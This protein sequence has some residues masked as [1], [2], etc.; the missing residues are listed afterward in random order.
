M[1]TTNNPNTVPYP[2][3]LVEAKYYYFG[4]PSRPL[5][6]ARSSTDVW[7]E[8]RG[9]EAY[10]LPRESSPIGLHPLREIW[11]AT[12]GPALVHYLDSKG[13][14]WTSLDPV[15]MGYTHESSHPVIIWIGVVAGSLSAEDGVQVAT[16]CKSILSAHD[17]NDV[18]VEIRESEVIRSAGPKMCKPTVTS[19][20][21]SEV[22]EPFST[23]LGLPICAEATPSIEGTGGFF[24]SDPRNP[25]KIYLVTARHVVFHPDND[26]NEFYEHSNPSQCRRNVLLFCDAAVEQH[27][28]A[29]ELEIHFKRT[30][31]EYLERPFEDAKLMDEEER[32]RA[33]TQLEEARKA[34]EILEKFLADC[35]DWKK[36]ENRVLGHVVLSPP[37]GFN[38]G[39]DGSTEDWAVIEIDDSKV[40]STNLLGN[41][42]DLCITDPIYKFS[43]W[44]TC[45]HPNAPYFE[46]PEERLFEISGTIADEEMWKPSPKTLDHNKDLCIMVLKRGYA[47]D[48]T[49]GRLNNIR[50]FTKVYFKDQPSQMSM[51]ITVLPRNSRLGAFS[52]PGDSGSA[53][54]D[55]QG[56]LAGLLTGGAGNTKV[57][58]CTYLTSINFLQRRMLEH[59]L[60][61]NLF[62]VNV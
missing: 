5:L 19:H 43:T 61:A 20:P 7:E 47:T 11:E 14:K 34:V 26:S 8:P 30:D 42:I 41:I 37:I 18:H 48:L 10:H 51:E 32:N 13:V 1:D 22:R 25:G 15:R 46:Y 62:P 57:S 4:T 38:V 55:S 50:S 23:T 58:D 36:R 54:V 60:K 39:E 16:R 44:M 52:R 12:V 28:R 2:P 35:S 45:P 3:P 17:I 53:V 6:V 24:I 56:R 40:D 27:I 49:V 29:I 31:I 21:T 59:G 9:L 33:L